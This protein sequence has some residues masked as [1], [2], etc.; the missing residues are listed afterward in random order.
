MTVNYNFSDS[1]SPDLHHVLGRRAVQAAGGLG[2]QSAGRSIHPYDFDGT[3]VAEDLRL[4]SNLDGTIR[5]H[6]RRVPVARGRRRRHVH[7]RIHRPRHQFRRQ[8]RFQDCIDSAATIGTPNSR[9]SPRVAPSRTTTSRRATAPRLFRRRL[10]ADGRGKTALRH[11]Y[12]HDTGD[13]NGSAR[14]SSAATASNSA[15]L[16]PGS[17]DVPGPTTRRSYSTRRSRA[18]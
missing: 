16:I 17:P 1:Y 9:S 8:P 7:Q 5:L 12:T 4:T 18:G 2:R 3:Q 11:R 13:I 10:P 14:C 15:N 6:S